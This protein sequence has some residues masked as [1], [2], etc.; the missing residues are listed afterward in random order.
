MRN[1]YDA[2][3]LQSKTA[4]NMII[5]I[6]DLDSAL[7]KCRD[8]LKGKDEHEL[9][10]LQSLHLEV[11]SLKRLHKKSLNSLRGFK[12]KT[13]SEQLK[14]INSEAHSERYKPPLK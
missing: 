8:L 10:N 4:A 12:Q 13:H 3:I 11:K 1:R 7:F 5:L 9:Y 14:Y 6:K 2:S